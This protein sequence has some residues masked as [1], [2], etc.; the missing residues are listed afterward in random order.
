MHSNWG[1]KSDRLLYFK[2]NL[3]FLNSER[4][5]GITHH[6]KK[7]GDKMEIMHLPAL[8]NLSDGYLATI[9]TR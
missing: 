5:L 1:H 2:N 7:Q 4:G 8:P 9:I 6:H 3:K